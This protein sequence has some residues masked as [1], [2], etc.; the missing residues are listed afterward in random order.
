MEVEVAGVS[1]ASTSAPAFAS[2]LA[3]F[4]AFAA[5]SS[6]W[7]VFSTS[8]VASGGAIM[9]RGATG[10][11]RLVGP[12]LKESDSRLLK[13]AAG[14]SPPHRIDTVEAGAEASGHRLTVEGDGDRALV[15]VHA[16]ADHVAWLPL[17]LQSALD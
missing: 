16:Q 15:E 2:A 17:R 6:S 3:S 1:G 4:F 11:C 10:A 13:E 7:Y 5:S 9:T 8:S 12:K 14:K